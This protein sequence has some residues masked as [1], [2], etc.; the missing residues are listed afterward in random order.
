M[1]CQV[2]GAESGK[3]PL[4]RACNLKKDSGEISKCTKCKTWHYVNQPCPLSSL[5]KEKRDFLYD[6][7]VS[8]ISKTEKAFFDAIKSSLS[9]NH[10]VF[11]QVNLASFISRTDNAPFHNEL[12]RNVDF[13]I[14]DS[15][16][17]PKIVVEINDSTHLNLDR[18]ERDEKVRKICE[19]AGIP[20]IKL[21]TSYGVNNDYIKS[22][23][24]DTLN[25]LPIARVSHFNQPHIAVPSLS[26]QQFSSTSTVY[27]TEKTSSKS[28]HLSPPKKGCYIATC[29]YGSYNCPNVWILRR[30]R[31]QYLSKTFLGKIFIKI[32][33]SISPILVKHFGTKILFRNCF[34]VFLN[35]LV[36][37]LKSVG[38]E[39]TPYND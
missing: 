19:E 22:K 13:L 30:F 17:R 11:P 34:K 33:Y 39:N 14:T 35:P 18:K 25:S 7:K 2:C 5:P 3:Y 38:F 37:F 10:Y 20:I 8:L 28:Q 21:W 29:V 9:E 1:K 12:F 32:Y 23:I 6:S 15:N 36:A 31:D 4:C 16:Y 27:P 26:N 24:T